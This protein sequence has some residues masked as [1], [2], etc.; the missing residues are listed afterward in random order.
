V[1]TWIDP[2]AR[3]FTFVAAD[4]TSDDGWAAAVAACDYVLHVASPFPLQQPKNE[5]DLIK[6]AREG[7]LR[8]LR[9]VAA[10]GVRHVVV[11]SSFAAIGY[12]PNH[13]GCLMTSPTG[14]TRLAS[15]VRT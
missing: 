1:R 15:R 2:G 4:L 5:N 13:P 12:S 14:P 10:A 11:T 9:A 8:V 6:P 3:K 7:T